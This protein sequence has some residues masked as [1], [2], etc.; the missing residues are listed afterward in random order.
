MEAQK[1]LDIDYYRKELETA[2][3]DLHAARNEIE[4]LQKECNDLREEID[5]ISHED[6]IIITTKHPIENIEIYF[7][8]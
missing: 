5:K 6:E 7:K 2:I 8:K 3:R 4:Y 1:I